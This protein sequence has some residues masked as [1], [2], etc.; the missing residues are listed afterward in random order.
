MIPALGRSP[1]E[2]NGYPLQYSCLGNPMGR[3]AWQATV[4]EQQESDTT[5]LF[6]N[7]HLFLCSN[8]PRFGQQESSCCPHHSVTTFLLF[9]TRCLGLISFILNLI[10]K[11]ASSERNGSYQCRMTL[12]NQDLYAKCVHVLI[13][14]E[15]SLLLVLLSSCRKYITLA[16]MLH[17][18]LLYICVCVC[19]LIKR[20][21]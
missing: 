1:G 5:Q 20:L 17:T 2:E 6:S 8:C 11:V 12:R 4:T 18:S 13:A 10:L 3:D 15:M 19:I 7:S 14:T 21:S 9:Q 16:Y